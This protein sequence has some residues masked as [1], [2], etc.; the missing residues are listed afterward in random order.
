MAGKALLL[1]SSSGRHNRHGDATGTAARVAEVDA[2]GVHQI[3]G[4]LD[5]AAMSMACPP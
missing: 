2:V 5:R 1:R 4:V 3:A